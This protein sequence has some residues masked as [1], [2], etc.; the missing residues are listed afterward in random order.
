MKHTQLQNRPVVTHPYR[1]EAKK[2]EIVRNGVRL[3]LCEGVKTKSPPSAPFVRDN[4]ISASTRVASSSSVGFSTIDGME[5]TTPASLRR[6]AE[7][8]ANKRECPPRSKKS[9]DGWIL[10]SGTFNKRAHWRA[11]S[12]QYNARQKHFRGGGNE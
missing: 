12:L 4:V 11:T 6:A 1:K 5:T 7:S 8:L 9:D 2:C 3:Y 10:D